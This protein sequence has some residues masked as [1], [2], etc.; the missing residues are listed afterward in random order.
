MLTIHQLYTFELIWVLS[1]Y[2]A[3]F[4]PLKMMTKE[5]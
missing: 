1:L 3:D 2:F 4:S 5:L